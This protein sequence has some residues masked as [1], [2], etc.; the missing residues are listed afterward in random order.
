MEKFHLN[1]A[2]QDESFLCEWL[3]SELFRLAGYPAPRVGHVRL[4]IN[5]RDM[6]LYVLR[7]GFDE[8]FMK[9]AFGS[10][11]GNLYDGGFLTDI[12][13][14]LETDLGDAS[15]RQDLIGLAL[16]CHTSDPDRRIAMIEERLDMDK[17]LRFM[18]IERLLGHWD[19]YTLNM[20]NYRVFFPAKGKAVFLPH[21]MDQLFGDPHAGLYDHSSPLLAA[22][23]MQ[24]DSLRARYQQT[25]KSLSKLLHPSNAWLSRMD[26]QR[27][28]LV[29]VL[30]SIDPT[31]SNAH[32]DRINELKDRVQQRVEAL[33]S[34]INE[35]MSE[36][37]ELAA[38]ES[39]QLTDW[40]AAVEAENIR[41]E[42]RAIGDVKCFAIEREVFGDFSSSWRK[43]VLLQRGKY[44]LE[45]RVK[46]EDVIPIGDESGRG[47][48]IRTSR[49][50]RSNEV[51]ST[52][53]WTR[54]SYEFSVVEDQ[55]MVELVLELRARFGKAW[56]DR[57]S[58]KLT[59]E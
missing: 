11:D 14:Q 48:G 46:T 37:L 12:D 9:R 27:E 34:L 22:A 1:N 54:I 4:W 45:A 26:K 42:E 5:D 31:L 24:N 57:E 13:S 3:G 59:R 18:A 56:F 19:G 2:S 23:V 44:L 15:N 53:D 8:P 30:A 29:P 7:E 40:Y 20:N 50:S 33:Q 51:V 38:G 35:G 10:S 58:L 25:L 47:A 36:T 28:K 39:I 41:V 6:G 52:S 17:F 32:H 21:G 49:A 16:A 43:Q 55:R